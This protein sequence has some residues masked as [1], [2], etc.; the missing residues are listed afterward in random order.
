[1]NSAEEIKEDN[2]IIDYINTYKTNCRMKTRGMEK[3]V[4]SC[5]I[6]HEK[7]LKNERYFFIYNLSLPISICYGCY[8]KDKGFYDGLY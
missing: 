4:T 1:M 8:L 3:G 7:R 5:G 2:I 6:C